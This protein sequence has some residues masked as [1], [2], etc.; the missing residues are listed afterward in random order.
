MISYGPFAEFEELIFLW[1]RAEVER[2]TLAIHGFTHRTHSIEF[3]A[4]ES[5]LLPA[6][7][8]A[9]MGNPFIMMK[10]YVCIR[11]HSC[12]YHVPE[13]IGDVAVSLYVRNIQVSDHYH[14]D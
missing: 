9:T 13:S 11:L 14:S 4:K 10:A 3:F 7:H 8:K 12:N 5:V 6:L 2:V 1:I